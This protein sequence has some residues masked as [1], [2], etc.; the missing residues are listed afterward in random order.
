[1]K[2]VELV[3][4]G[5]NLVAG[6]KLARG[7]GKDLETT[8]LKLTKRGRSIQEARGGYTIG[9]KNHLQGNDKTWRKSPSMTN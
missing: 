1:M 7:K 4:A 5:A 6:E 8:M 2:E 3:S 9:N